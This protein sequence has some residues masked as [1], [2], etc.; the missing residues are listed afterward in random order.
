[1]KKTL[2]LLTVIASVIVLVLIDSTPTQS[3]PTGAPAGNTGSPGDGKTCATSS[4]HAGTAQTKAG[5]ISSDIPSSG[6]VPG[7]T[8]NI[9]VSISQPGI[10]RWGFQISPQD[11]AGNR[12]GTLSL[13]N[14]IETKLTLS[15]YV[16]HTSNG[17]SGS[18]TKTWSF[19]WKAPSA[20]TGSVPFYAA[21]MAANNNGGT[22]GDQVFTDVMTINESAPTSLKDIAEF[23]FIIFP[24]PVSDN[25]LQIQCNT[26]L[27]EQIKNIRI[28]D[29]SGK[30]QNF[31]YNPGKMI[32]SNT[33]NI[34]LENI[35][36]GIYLLEIQNESGKW[37]ERFLKN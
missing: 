22:S 7:S 26:N 34:P 3:N 6:Y 8:Y 33:L 10:N 15:T 21:V 5:M 37:V 23:D 35:K 24:Q 30:I 13:S 14:T 12:L 36:P 2:T 11:N 29:I 16:T 4:C 18:G 17:T 1:M 9:T 25:M 19:K 20:G 28:I 31:S 32:T 27:I